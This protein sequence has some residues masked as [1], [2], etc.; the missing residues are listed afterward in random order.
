MGTVE[1]IDEILAYLRAVKSMALNGPTS[2]DTAA[3]TNTSALIRQLG[4]SIESLTTTTDQMRE[5][6]DRWPE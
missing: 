5:R 1:Q 6:R 4:E 2:E 3:L